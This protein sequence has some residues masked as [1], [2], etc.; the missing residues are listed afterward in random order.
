M[1]RLMARVRDEISGATKGGI[2]AAT[3]RGAR[4]RRRTRWESHCTRCGLC[5]YEKERHGRSVVTN[6]RRPCVYLDVASRLCTVYE[7]RFAVCAQCRRMTLIHAL[8]VKW[9]PPSCGYVQRYRRAGKR[10]LA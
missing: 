7:N 3:I 1:T 8:F 2:L 6:Y 4:S 10:Q 5:C 9:L